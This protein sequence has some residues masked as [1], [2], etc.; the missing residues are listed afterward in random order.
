MRAYRA[1]VWCSGNSLTRYVEIISECEDCQGAGVV[2]VDG[3]LIDCEAC[4][5]SGEVRSYR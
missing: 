2:T 4:G 1:D 3:V 5:G